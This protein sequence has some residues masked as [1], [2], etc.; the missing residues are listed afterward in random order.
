MKV[1]LFIDTSS[2]EEIQVA[3]DING[4]RLEKTAPR[5]ARAQMVLPMIEELLSEQKLK[6]TDIAEIKVNPGPGSFTGLRVGL[7]V[8]Q[9][10]GKLLNVPVNGKRAGA[11]KPIY[12]KSKWE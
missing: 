1:I 7:A 6:L 2:S 3:I 8:A 9:T 12:Q 11:I 4:K 5:Q 10:L